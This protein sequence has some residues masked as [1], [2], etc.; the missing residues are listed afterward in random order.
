[1][2]W[3]KLSE[4]QSNLGFYY[5]GTCLLFAGYNLTRTHGIFNWHFTPAAV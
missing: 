5:H 4:Y 2:D 1:M 3:G